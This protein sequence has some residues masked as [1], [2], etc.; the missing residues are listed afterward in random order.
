MNSGLIDNCK[1]VDCAVSNTYWQ[2][3][4]LIG[5]VN[6]GSVKNCTVQ[7]SSI[8]SKSA[9]GAISGPVTN[10]SDEDIVFENCTVENCQ[11]NQDGS[12]G[13]SYDKYFG[14]MFGYLEAAEGKRIIINNCTAT[15]TTVKGS[16]NAPISGDFDGTIYID[17]GLVVTTAEQLAAA[18]EAGGKCVLV[19]N[20]V[21]T[22]ALSKSNA[23]FSLNGNGY[24]ISMAEDCTNTYAMFDITGGKI[25]FENVVFDGIKDGAVVRTVGVEFT[26]DNVTAQN[27]NHTQQQGLFRLMGKSTIT[28]CTFKNNTCSMVITLNYDGANNDPQVVEN[29]VFEG[30]NANATAVLYYVKGASCTLNNNKFVGNTVNCSGNGATVYMGFQEN[31][32]V[33][34]NI[35]KN[36]TVNEAGDSSRVAGGIFFGYDMEFTGNAFIGNK[37][38]GTN[39]KGNDVCVST[40]Y[41]DI[42]LS[43]NYWGGKAPVEDVNYFVQHKTSGNKVIVNDYLSSYAE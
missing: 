27:G 30:N 1:I 20:I 24:T 35:F 19:N 9:I 28:N 8:T 21:M 3:G 41:T 31:C 14:T 34:N 29:C 13:G 33:T 2:G 15:N 18:L 7:N 16:N 36:N 12:F 5:Q 38:T 37:V 39:A 43:G 40:Y 6:G 26:A 32:S 42:D 23:N 22:N 10:E 11:I 4:I 25:A 17:G